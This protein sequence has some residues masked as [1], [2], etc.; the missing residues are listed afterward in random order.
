[1]TVLRIVP[2]F[3]ADAPG[4]TARFYEELFGLDRTMDM[5]WIITLTSGASMI[6][7]LSFM[8]EGGSG[9]QVP[10]ISVEVDDVDA[11]HSRAEKAGCD[12][13]YPLVD[14]PWGVRRFYVRDP[15]GR[16]VNV[17]SHSIQQ[18]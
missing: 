15:Q 6:P 2:N 10:D 3:K 16:T 18:D 12:I 4:E 13:V 9:T 17:L 7:Q 14:E 1:M 5:G 8:Q 11:A